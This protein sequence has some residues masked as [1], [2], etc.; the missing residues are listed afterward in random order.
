MLNQTSSSQKHEKS[1]RKQQNAPILHVE[2]Q[3]AGW[4]TE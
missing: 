4:G 1:R 2:E 3:V